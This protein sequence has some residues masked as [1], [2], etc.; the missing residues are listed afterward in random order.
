[1][2]IEIGSRVA[3]EAV[4]AIKGTVQRESD[5]L[6]WN[7]KWDDGKSRDPFKSQQLKELPTDAP[8]ASITITQGKCRLF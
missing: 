3:M 1:M 7:V 8:P 6:S 2:A 5:T 4:A